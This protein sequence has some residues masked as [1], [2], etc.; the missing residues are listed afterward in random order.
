M[1]SNKNL[2]ETF[3]KDLL[4]I[5]KVKNCGY[6]YDQKCLYFQLL[7]V[8]LCVRA[9]V[10]V[11]VFVCVCVC[12]SIYP[13]GFICL[14]QVGYQGTDQRCYVE[15]VKFLCRFPSSLLRIKNVTFQLAA[16]SCSHTRSG[17]SHDLTSVRLAFSMGPSFTIQQE[18]PSVRTTS[19]ANLLSDMTREGSQYI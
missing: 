8:C 18:S 4:K 3:D 1:N 9:C 11:C 6:N 13:E 15:D 7:L 2:Y 14:D 10:R 19:W 5:R 12:T 16:L 17:Q